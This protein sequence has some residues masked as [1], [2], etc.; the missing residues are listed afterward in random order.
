MSHVFIIKYSEK[1]FIIPKEDFTN[2][3][4]YFFFYFKTIKTRTIFNNM[5]Y[6]YRYNFKYTQEVRAFEYHYIK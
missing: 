4:D 3:Y 1:S 5:N 2:Y 6:Y